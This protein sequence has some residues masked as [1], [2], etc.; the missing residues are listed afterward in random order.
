MAGTREGCHR[1]ERGRA[2]DNRTLNVKYAVVNAA[3]FM[4]VCASSGYAYNYLSA[5]GLAD[6]TIGIIIAA[7][8]VLSAIGQA[9]FSG[10]VDRSKTL[11]E[12]GFISIL[13][14]VTVALSLAV[15]LFTG[16]FLFMALFVVA[17]AS[18]TVGLPFLNSM[19]FIYEHTGH[20]INYGLGR[21]VGSA[22]YAVGG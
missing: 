13:M 17:V 3:F 16:N 9:V 6:G 8:S 4:F 22:A 10:V 5:A 19:A 7:A 15:L 12:K 2:M 1:A 18:K 14:V 21:G 11:D 20:S